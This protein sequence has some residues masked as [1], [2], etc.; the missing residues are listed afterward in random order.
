MPQLALNSFST[1]SPEASGG[2]GWIIEGR[3]E[4]GR[5]KGANI[6]VS[7]HVMQQQEQQQNDSIP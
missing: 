7:Q 2:A 6:T 5:G 4:T 1:V 3:G